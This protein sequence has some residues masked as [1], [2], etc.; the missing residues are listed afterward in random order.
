[1]EWTLGRFQQIIE[2]E[3]FVI[4]FRFQ[5]V[6][7]LDSL[8]FGMRFL[9][10]LVFH[11]IEKLLPL[12]PADRIKRIHLAGL[13]PE[14]TG[15]VESQIDRIDDSVLFRR[16]Q[17]DHEAIRHGEPGKF[18]FRGPGVRPRRLSLLGRPLPLGGSFRL[19]HFRN[20]RFCRLG[21]GYA[22]FGFVRKQ[23]S[24]RAERIHCDV[25]PPCR[26]PVDEP[27]KNRF[28]NQPRNFPGDRLKFFRAIARGFF[29]LFSIKGAQGDI[30]ILVVA[31]GNSKLNLR[32]REFEHR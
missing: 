24:L 28:S 16:D 5:F 2:D 3:N 19:S 14:A 18:F 30:G 4:T 31:S 17:L 13:R 1:M 9:R 23:L 12:H 7:V 10:F 15:I 25:P 32:P 22:F 11:Q 29:D 26:V 6:E 21:Q 27:D 20:G 8:E